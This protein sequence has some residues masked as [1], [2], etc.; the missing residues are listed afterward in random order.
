MDTSEIQ[1]HLT[2][3]SGW[4]SENSCL[5]KEFHFSNFMESMSF[6]NKI[7]PLAEEMGHHPEL[8]IEYSKVT[9][10]L[11]THDEGG[12]TQKDLDLALKIDQI[13]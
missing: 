8:K 4:K 11:S 3:I 12:V 5:V 9:V 1:R 10:T 7:V 13:K 2:E 6:V